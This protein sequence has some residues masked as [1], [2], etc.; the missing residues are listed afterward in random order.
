MKRFIPYSFLFLFFIQFLV[1]CSKRLELTPQDQI[2]TNAFWK[3]S[4]DAL[5]A[6][7]ACYS[8]LQYGFNY[9]YDDGSSDNAYAQYPW[10]SNATYI[11]AGNVDPS[12]DAG[13]NS[14]YQSIRT[15][16]YFLDNIDKAPMMTPRKDGILP[17]PA[18]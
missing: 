8:S 4:R 17:K 1:G 3:S 18:P 13:Y 14:R 6:L 12:L 16:N 10:E 7:N 9:A 11:S 2:S 15:L 5:L